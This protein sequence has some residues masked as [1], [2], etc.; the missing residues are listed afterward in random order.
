MTFD[1]MQTIEACVA[2]LVPVGQP[3]PPVMRALTYD[4]V[5]IDLSKWDDVLPRMAL[6]D[7]LSRELGRIGHPEWE[8]WAPS[9]GASTLYVS[10]REEP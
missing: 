2:S 3:R 4:R 8:V 6:L 5:E 1:D 7:D 9:R 10:E